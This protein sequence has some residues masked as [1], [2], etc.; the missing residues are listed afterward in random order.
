VELFLTHEKRKQRVG[1]HEKRKHKTRGRRKAEGWSL[2][3]LEFM[4]VVSFR[5][6]VGRYARAGDRPDITFT[7]H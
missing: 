4:P 2:F 7:G 3:S 1:A 6:K 5:Q